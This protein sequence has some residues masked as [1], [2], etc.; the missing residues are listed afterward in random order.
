[1]HCLFP[2]CYG[3]YIYF[4]Q[5]TLFAPQAVYERLGYK[6][7]SFL[8][9]LA[10]SSSCCNPITYCFMN[11]SFRRAFLKLFGCLREEKGSS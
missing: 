10:Y 4:L 7:I 2:N 11:S 8:Q 6:G 9:L 1:M 5:I 3:S